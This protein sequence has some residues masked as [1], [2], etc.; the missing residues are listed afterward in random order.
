MTT[1]RQYLLKPKRVHTIGF[2]LHE[3][4]RGKPK[5]LCDTSQDDGY[6]NGGGYK[7]LIG[8]P[9][10]VVRSRKSL[11][12]DLDAGHRNVSGCEIH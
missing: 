4:H 10:S 6:T 9:R 11:F 2:Y 12:P 5:P 8:I 7:C 1:I 3:E